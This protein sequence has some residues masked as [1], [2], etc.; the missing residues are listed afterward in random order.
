MRLKQRTSNN[1][2]LQGCFIKEPSVNFSAE[3]ISKIND[4]TQWMGLT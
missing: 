3:T 1:T 4:S 2:N